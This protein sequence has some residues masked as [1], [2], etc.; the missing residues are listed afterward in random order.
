MP[1]QLTLDLTQHWKTPRWKAALRRHKLSAPLA[2]AVE[3][4]ILTPG[5]SHLDIGCGRGGDVRHLKAMGYEATGFDPYYAPD[6]EKQPADVVSLCYVLGVVEDPV[7]R[8]Q[9]LEEA[10]ALTKKKLLVAT[11]VQH[12]RGTI[13][14]GDG[15]LTAWKT[16]AKY[17]NEP[18]FRQYVEEVTGA[19]AKRLG[20][21]ILLVQK[22]QLSESTVDAPSGE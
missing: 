7:E 4:K 2:L 22:E 12:S 14:Y 18:G 16:F 5:L 19:K 20:K 6:T 1:N 11:Q 9:I 10:W 13:P 21:G 15:Y 3:K 17:W 8:R